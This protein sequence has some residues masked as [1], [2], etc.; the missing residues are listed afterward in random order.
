MSRKSH[1]MLGAAAAHSKKIKAGRGSRTTATILPSTFAVVDPP[2]V[3]SNTRGKRLPSSA[4]LQKLGDQIQRRK[5]AYL[6]EKL[7]A[8]TI[9]VPTRSTLVLRV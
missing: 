3:T 2:L 5:S 4:V 1:V 7:A 8:T 6:L 9:R